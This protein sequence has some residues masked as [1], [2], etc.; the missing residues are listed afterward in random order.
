[1][2]KLVALLG[3]W[4]CG[5][6]LYAQDSLKQL[7]LTE[8]LEWSIAFHPIIRQAGIQPGFADAELRIAKGSFDPKISSSL[9][10]KEYDGTTYYNK[11]RSN[12]KIP[13]WFP[14]DPKIE[15]NRD[16]GDYLNREN[17]VSG[18]D[19]WQMSTG[20]SIPL[21]K[22]LIIDQRRTLV[23]QAKV[24]GQMAQA[25]QV[26]LTNKMLL[27]IVK[28][29]RDWEL[30]YLKFELMQQS[31][32]IALELFRRVKVDYTLGSAAVVDTLQA[33]IILQSRQI[34]LETSQLELTQARQNMAVHLWTANDIPL[35]LDET[36]IPSAY[37]SFG[38]VP[39]DSSIQIIQSWSA[40][41]HPA[42]QKLNGKKSQ[43]EMEQRWNKEQLKPELNLSYSLIN[44]PLAPTG[45][46]TPQWQDNYKIGAD[47]SIPIFLRKERGKL[48]KTSLYLESTELA[49]AQLRR[50]VSAQIQNTYSALQTNREL[51][52]RYEEM[53][54]NYQ[55]LLN[56]ELFN[57]ETGESDLFKL[58]IQQD[59]YIEAQIKYFEAR[60]KFEKLKAELP[61]AAGLPLLSYE[62]LYE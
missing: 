50:E 35:E 23:K 3:I 39:A 31:L 9:D 51:T 53:A 22:G 6:P 62:S 40:L 13:L 17:Y 16:Q 18:N 4:F 36:T 12:F 55:S 15:I 58:N 8:V 11:F 20:I 30:T 10:L 42:I 2:K 61:H 5:I 43:L 24:F 34:A 41:N 28:D 57:L 1:M 7:S 45:I 46:E 47:F 37:G 14:I 56:A 26:K 49:L 21:G 19:Y 25:E 44:A 60:T 59:K 27:D 29:Y 54:L 33:K 48:Q 32:E 52:W 38:L